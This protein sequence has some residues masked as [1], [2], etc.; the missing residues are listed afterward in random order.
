M[1]LGA[2]TL[3][4]DL[5]LDFRNMFAESREYW[6]VRA[7]ALL[8]SMS[9]VLLTI[10]SINNELIAEQKFSFASDFSKKVGNFTTKSVK[11]E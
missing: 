8:Q 9:L 4:N 10:E 2:I 1:E 6:S 7:K 5:W 11:A 3:H